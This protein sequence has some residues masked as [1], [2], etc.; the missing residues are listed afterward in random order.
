VSYNYGAQVEYVG[1]WWRVLA[2]II[3]SIVTGIV[4]AIAGFI[5]GLVVGMGMGPGGAAQQTAE[6]IA[7]GVGIIIGWLYW[8]LMESSAQQATLGK[9][10][11][12]VI[13]TDLAGNRISF[14]RATGRHFAKILSALILCIGYIMVAFT[15]KKQGLHDQIANTL[16]V[17]KRT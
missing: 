7:Q 3:D 11:I 14:G 8:A 12:G 2:Y 13:V 5:V 9:M 17:K 1:F 10:A 4:G 15:E 6:W 16:V